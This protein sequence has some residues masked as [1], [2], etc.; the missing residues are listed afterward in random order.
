MI[1]FNKRKTVESRIDYCNIIYN[2]SI[3]I[4]TLTQN[5]YNFYFEKN[6]SPNKYMDQYTAEI[7]IFVYFMIMMKYE[8]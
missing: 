8:Y 6:V 5:S 3:V 7:L 4:T 1:V 2:C